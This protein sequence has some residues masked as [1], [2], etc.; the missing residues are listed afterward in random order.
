M[1]NDIVPYPMHQETV[2]AVPNPDELAWFGDKNN[3]LPRTIGTITAN[4]RYRTNSPKIS[5]FTFRKR[6]HFK[7]DFTTERKR[8]NSK[9]AL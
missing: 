5:Y 6:K 2:Q 3:E 9:L 4:N 8:Q 7:V 1:M